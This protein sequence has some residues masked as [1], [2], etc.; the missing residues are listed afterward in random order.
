[1]K[2]ILLSNH[3][4]GK[5]LDILKRAVGEDFQLKVLTK[6][7]HGELLDAVTQADYL[8][9]SGRLRIDREVIDR[10]QRVRM[11]QRTGVGLD[12]IDTAY[13]KSKGIP[14]YVNRGVNAN[15]VAEYTVM[16]MLAALKRN[17]AINSQIRGHIWK[18]Q[19]TGLTTHEIQGKTIGMVGMGNIGKRVAKML[20]GFDVNI[21][22]TCRRQLPE[23][24]E[25]RLGICYVTFAD[26]LAQSDL[27]SL[28]CPYDP[29]KGYLIAEDEIGQMKPGAILINT[30]RGK[31]VKESAAA[32]ALS[33]G[34]LSAVGIDVF[35]EEP[36][37]QACAY[38]DSPEAILSPHVA[39]LSYETFVRMMTMA[40]EN[41]RA[42]DR[43]D[44]EC[45]ASSLYT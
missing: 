21:L 2:T 3:Y 12:N 33:S 26:L 40:V 31:L 45:I 14:L 37:G 7:E 16:L 5:P 4:A 36:V 17:Y 44:L 10:A 9:V 30:A 42:F 28:H 43:G 25:Q 27:V 1:M 38:L 15:S 8:I 35:E 20:G 18:K 6:A 11:I 19:E 23:E 13:L 29:E 22:Y 34:K 32:E 24:E 39:G 41:I